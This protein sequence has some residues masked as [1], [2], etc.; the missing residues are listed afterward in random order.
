MTIFS[1]EFC[2]SGN[3]LPFF[4][5]NINL[6]ISKTPRTA[7]KILTFTLQI[8]KFYLIFIINFT[9]QSLNLNVGT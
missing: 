3:D 2:T 9:T 1:I 6:C 8:F 5:R 7:V 4:Q